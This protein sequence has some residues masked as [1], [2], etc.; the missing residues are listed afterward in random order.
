VSVE[1]FASD[2]CDFPVK[3]NLQAKTMLHFTSRQCVSGGGGNQ[4]R[5]L[6]ASAS[7]SSSTGHRQI[8]RL[9]SS[10]T[11]QPA[12]ETESTGEE[13]SQSIPRKGSS[14]DSILER[15]Q[16]KMNNASVASVM[17]VLAT[18]DAARPMILETI[19]ADKATKP[20]KGDTTSQDGDVKQRDKIRQLFSQLEDLKQVSGFP[21]WSII[22][23]LSA[24]AEM[25]LDSSNCKAV[26]TL[27]NR[28]TWKARSVPMKDL[29]Q[30][31]AHASKIKR[32]T[33]G[34]IDPKSTT[35]IM[36]SE[37]I[38]VVEARW[39]E[40]DTPS[41]FRD[42]Y[43]YYPN[44]CGE[45]F[46][47]KLDDKAMEM[48]EQL[49]GEELA[50]ILKTLAQKKRRNVPLVR[51]LAYHLEKRLMNLNLET[52]C[53][54]LHSL[55]QLSFKSN[56]TLLSECC[57]EA[58]KLIGIETHSTAIRSLLTS[59]GQLK[60]QQKP[61]LNKISQHL[62]LKLKS[63]DPN[64]TVSDEELYAFTLCT[65]AV[66]YCPTE[67]QELYEAIVNRL[68]R[69]RIKSSI[70]RWTN[71]ELPWLDFVWSLC[72][73]GKATSEQLSTVLSEDFYHQIIYSNNNRKV[74]PILKLLNVN[75][76]ASLL[77]QPSYN[78][79]QVK[80]NPSATDEA[81]PLSDIKGPVTQDKRQVVKQVMDAMASLASGPLFMSVDAN[82]GMG[83]NVEG[84]VVFDKNLKPLKIE[85]IKILGSNKISSST[86]PSMPPDSN[87]VA[88]LVVG[89]HDC[90]LDGIDVN[91]LTDLKIRL[92]EAKGFK[93]LI[94][95]HSDLKPKENTLDRVKMIQHRLKILLNV[96]NLEN[97]SKGDK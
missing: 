47:T 48:S 13:E 92:L 43:F 94:I 31:L 38:R 66:N 25:G 36:M 45:Q 68:T 89:Y 46:A 67:S 88:L 63:E 50:L 83:F 60:L 12:A 75:G 27:E 49:S 22:T 81:L 4:A 39:V 35:S 82:T 72:L 58:E 14:M 3:N 17:K 2:R 41:L 26:M 84:E 90:L 34:Q 1:L 11:D 64:H 15:V 87:R 73:L 80:S 52:F 97:V 56:P 53:E 6:F 18:S 79:P 8:S 44:F 54:I 30:I 42:F 37:I 70:K 76:Y 85:P 32:D 69:D 78:G 16:P 57:Y 20:P 10:A 95:R 51:K 7:S 61:L 29:T 62:L 96:E 21:L 40:I 77:C 71:E 5:Y 86:S 59:L 93:V 9:L 19:A 24:A 91:G 55:S 33:Q 28:L 65:A 23:C 74:G